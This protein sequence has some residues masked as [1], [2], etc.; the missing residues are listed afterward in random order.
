MSEILV[1]NFY[2]DTVSIEEVHVYGL[3][4]SVKASKYPKA[5]NTEST[6]NVITASTKALG[7]AH[8]GSGHDC[9]LKGIVVQFDIDWGIKEWTEA[10]RYHWFD[11]VSSQSTMHCIEKFDVYTQCNDYV[12]PTIKE[13]LAR[14]KTT[15]LNDPTEQNFFKLIY[16]VPV[17]FR[18]KAHIT[19]NYMQ[20]K[21][22]KQQRKHHR[23]DS[24]K[25]F[26][27]FVD[28]LPYFTSLTEKDDK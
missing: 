2:S 9:F 22:I 12:S 16:S 27:I 10:E 5:T 8:T 26:C 20:L 3:R 28:T 21:T 7:R 14:L 11:I 24:W 25:D 23:L 4:E 19:T 13:E 15:Y 18:L 1:N 6:T 17:G